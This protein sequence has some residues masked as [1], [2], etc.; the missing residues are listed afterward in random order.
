MSYLSFLLDKFPIRKTGPQKDAFRT[1]IK[2]EAKKLGY[3]YSFHSPKAM[4]D[5]IVIGDPMTAEVTFTAH[6]DTPANMILPNLMIPRNL[7]VFFLYQMVVVGVLLILSLVIGVGA[8]LLLQNPD[9]GFVIGWLFYMFLLMMMLFGPANKHN[10]NDNTSGVAVILEMMAQIPPEQREKVAFIFFDNEEK[11]ML[12]SK[13]Y[14]K[15]NLEFQHTHLLINLDCVGVGEH[16]LFISPKLAVNHPAWEKLPVAFE[17]R[18]ERQVHFFPKAGSACNSDQKPFKCG[19][20]VVACKRAPVIGFYCDKIH[21]KKDTFADEGN[22]RFLAE[23][24]A[25]FV[26]RI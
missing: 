2:D 25:D 3:R 26:A 24:L 4:T 21:T 14:A 10:A 5:N 6:Y 23:G 1:Y 18:T 20:A 19:V 22:I 17:N 7:P 9:T 11:G 16:M 15:A 12:G 8:S 13:A